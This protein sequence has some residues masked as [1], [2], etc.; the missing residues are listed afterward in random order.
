MPHIKEQFQVAR[1]PILMTKAQ[2]LNPHRG[3]LAIKTEPFE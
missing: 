1:I 3:S 2:D